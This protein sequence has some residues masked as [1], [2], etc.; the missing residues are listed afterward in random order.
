M[1]KEKVYTTIGLMSGTSLDGIDA[2]LIRTDGQG[3]VDHIAVS[4]DEKK[5]AYSVASREKNKKRSHVIRLWDIVSFRKAARK[6]HP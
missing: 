6:L 2:A 5:L 4:R 1:G 3:F